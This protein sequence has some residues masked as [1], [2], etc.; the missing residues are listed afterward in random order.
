LILSCKPQG[1][2]TGTVGNRTAFKNPQAIDNIQMTRV[3]GQKCFLWPT[4]FSAR[5]SVPDRILL[6]VLLGVVFGLLDAAMVVFG[7]RP[8]NSRDASTGH[9]SVA[10]SSSASLR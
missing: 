7:K 6:G 10:S 5:E 4:K 3:I 2:D 9:F 8:D 1:L